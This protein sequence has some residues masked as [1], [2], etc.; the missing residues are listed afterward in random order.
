MKKVVLMAVLASAILSSCSLLK[1]NMEGASTPLEVED[2]NA[3]MAVRSFYKEFSGQVI[4]IADSIYHSTDD[5]ELKTKT[6][7]W[8][9]GSTS[10]CSRAAFQTDAE[11]A[12]V[13]TWIVTRQMNHFFENQGQE[14][15]DNYT[16]LATESSED[17]LRKIELIAKGT[18][19]KENFAQLKDFVYQYELHPIADD[20]KMER[21]DLRPDLI[22]HMGIPDSLY[23]KTVGSG[24]EVMSDLTDRLG[25]YN[26]QISS[27]LEWQKQLLLT[28]M[29]DSTLVAPYIARIDSMAATM[30]SLAIIMQESPEM[31]GMIAVRMREELS[32]IAQDFTYGMQNSILQ[33]SKERDELQKYISEQRVLLKADL[34]ESGQVLI[35]ETTDNLIRLIKSISWVIILLVIVLTAVF[36]GLPFTLGFLLG[37]WRV[38]RKLDK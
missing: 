24:A 11:L 32:P 7:Y 14:Y 35:K 37:K 12:L 27:Q 36:F 22:A 33:L 28:N 10:A 21:H 9:S 26:E 34:E 5:L 3:R 6:I 1:F 17:L 20:W 31:L 38:K 13:E 8:K 4:Q 29:E 23:T 15:F 2:L 30:R 19:K 16:H 18:R 25:I